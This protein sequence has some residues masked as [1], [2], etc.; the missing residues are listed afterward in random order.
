MIKQ[1]TERN[2]IRE[3]RKNNLSGIYFFERVLSSFR[4]LIVKGIDKKSILIIIDNYIEESDFYPNNE[5]IKEK[6]LILKNEIK[7]SGSLERL[8][9]LIDVEIINID[10]NNEVKLNER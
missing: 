7:K 3:L 5:K 2:L 6:L 10:K 9:S 1:Q 8:K 4:K